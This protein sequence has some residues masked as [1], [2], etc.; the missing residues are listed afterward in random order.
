[1]MDILLT[2][3]GFTRNWGGWLA[4]EAFEYVLGR[5]EIG[6]ELRQ[7][8]WADKMKGKGFEDTLGVLQQEASTG[9]PRAAEIVDEFLAALVAMFNEMNQGL[10]TAQF[11][12]QN[13]TAYLVGTYLARFDYIFTL[14]QDLLLEHHYLNGNIGLQLPR[15]F[16][17]WQMPGLKPLNPTAAAYD[18]AGRHVPMMTPDDPPFRISAGQQPYIKLHGSS[19]WMRQAGGR[20]LVLGGGKEIDI[21]REPLLNWYH[22]EFADV[23]KRPGAKLTVIGYSFGDKHVND[24]I[25]DAANTGSLSLFIIDPVGVDVLNKEGD[26]AMPANHPLIERLGPSVRGAS[27]RPLSATFGHDYVEHAKVLSFLGTP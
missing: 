10:A 23:L 14:N 15:K 1:M 22:K 16:S 3:A 18:P 20:L 11:E 17:G 13:V 6:V 5:P 21:R 8:L 26:I 24:A 12:P 7:R 27:R 19:S 25:G 4:N 2:G 9:R